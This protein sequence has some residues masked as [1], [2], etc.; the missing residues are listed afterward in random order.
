MTSYARKASFR[1]LGSRLTT[2]ATVLSAALAGAVVVLILGFV[3][4]SAVPAIREI[5]ISH[6]V[7]DSAWYP[8]QSLYRMTPMLVGTVAVGTLAV[9]LATPAGI[10]S[11]VFMRYYAK[12]PVASFYRAVVELLGGIPSVVYGF[13]GLMVIVPAL[14]RWF[15]PGSCL[16]TGGLVLALMILPTMTLTAD[17][18]LAAVPEEY[19]S[20]AAALGMSKSSTV[21][22]VALPCARGGLL[23]GL[24]LESGRAIGE[25]MAVLMVS[26][27][28]PLVPQSLF[29]PVRTLTANIALEMAYAVGKHRSALFVSGLAI[30]ALVIVLMVLATRHSVSGSRHG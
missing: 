16:L 25:T 12:G 15:P 13:W 26:G 4:A 23:S 10:L 14:A 20:G 5:G 22:R 9:L 27:N 19:L 2:T 6:F 3:V 21:V 28:I 18:A 30:G 8:T 7:T 1:L 24:L 17:A 29:S 11:A